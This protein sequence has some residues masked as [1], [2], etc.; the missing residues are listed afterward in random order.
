MKKASPR[1]TRDQ[2]TVVLEDI[3]DKVGLIREAVQPIPRI[4]EKLDATFDEV[5]NLRTETE[6]VKV[7]LKILGRDVEP[8]K[9]DMGIPKQ[10]VG[11]LKENVSVL[12]EDM[13]VV[14]GELR[15][16]K[17]DLKVKV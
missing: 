10:D 11:V 13:G 5:R 17:N 9:K 7:A 14:K 6:V 15:T 3:R 1:R 8:L 4:Q 2:Y 16:I 12:K